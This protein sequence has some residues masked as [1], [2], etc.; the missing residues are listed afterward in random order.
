MGIWIYEIFFLCILTFSPD[1]QTGK[2]TNKNIGFL[3]S[4]FIIFALKFF[5]VALSPTKVLPLISTLVY[6]SLFILV[7]LYPIKPE[8]FISVFVNCFAL[9]G[10]VMVI[11]FILRVQ[12]YG[13]E[14]I[15]YSKSEISDAAYWSPLTL[16][17][18]IPNRLSGPFAVNGGVNIAGLFFGLAQICNV[19]RASRKNFI[20]YTIIF[21]LAGGATGSRGFYLIFFL[22]TYLAQVFAPV[23]ENSRSS[24]KRWAT[25]ILS[26]FVSLLGL[27]LIFNSFNKSWESTL[28]G[29]GRSGIYST[30]WDHWSDNGLG[31]QM[32]GNF[33]EKMV[34]YGGFGGAHPH[35]S[36][37]EY[38]WNFGLVGAFS[39]IGAVA[40]LIFMAWNLRAISYVPLALL[41][42]VLLMQAERTLVLDMAQSIGFAWL[43][44]VNC[45]S[46]FQ[47]SVS[48]ES[49]DRS[50]Y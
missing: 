14:F 27:K 22:G 25:V 49:K 21:F 23:N 42:G 1:R 41:L 3:F 39:F 33:Q 43:L 46:Y 45:V 4:W 37:F 11:S 36:F 13:I 17:F 19:L 30:I 9:L 32:P 31:G 15:D 20:L 5:E 10:A 7:Y 24:F 26:F 38:L 8:I 34:Y 18:G 50:G 48:L 16:V 40:S 28:S 44:I 29:N 35:N 12:W 6:L 47:R 2:L